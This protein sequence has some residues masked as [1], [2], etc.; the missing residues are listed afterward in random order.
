MIEEQLIAYASY[1][2][3]IRTNPPI[4]EEAQFWMDIEMMVRP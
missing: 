3:W 1:L 2:Q 4:V